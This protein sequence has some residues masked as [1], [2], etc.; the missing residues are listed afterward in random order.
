MSPEEGKREFDF[1]EWLSEG[2][3]GLLGG[4]P[5]VTG[6]VPEEFKEHTRA[7][8][9]EMLLAYRSLLDAAIAKTEGEDESQ[10]TRIKV[11]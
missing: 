1:G 7:A 4:R 8:F 3:E 2:L 11:E 5:K 9:R 6:H 10:V